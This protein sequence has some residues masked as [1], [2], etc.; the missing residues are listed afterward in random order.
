MMITIEKV[1]EVTLELLE[2]ML[3]LVPQLTHTHPPPTPE[4][5]DA[6]LLSESATLFIARDAASG[7][8]VGMATLVLYR[9]PTGLRGYIED[10]VVDGNTRGQGIGEALTKACLNAAKKAGAPQVNL[11]SHPGRLAA[12]VLY[13]KMGFEP[14]N[15]NVYRY[16][17]KKG[18]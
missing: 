15:T 14:R 12:N 17:F 2:A 10:V 11:T 6:V 5:L 4:E 18:K 1:T 3:R 13:R 7:I 9:V 16:V 8:I